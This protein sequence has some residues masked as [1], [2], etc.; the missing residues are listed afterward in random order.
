MNVSHPLAA[1]ALLA[2]LAGA[3]RANLLANGSFESGNFAPPGNAT[4]S[5]PVGSTAITGWAVVGDVTSWIG[6]GNP[7]GLSASDGARFLD[8]TDYAPGVP[9]GGVTQT[10]ATQ[11]GATYRLS[12]DLGSSTYWGRVSAVQA[13]AGGSSAS[14]TGAASGGNDDWESFSMLFT[15]ASGS[16]AVTLQGLTGQWYIGLDNVAV[17]WVGGPPAAVPEPAAVW[18]LVA[19]IG[20]MAALR[21]PRT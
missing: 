14:F 8:L 13:S 9:F 1:A 19:G 12:F 21:Q 17:E 18:L 5:L 4:M 2:M 11:A 20:A 3:A 6:T 15:A 16:T 7:W 10:I